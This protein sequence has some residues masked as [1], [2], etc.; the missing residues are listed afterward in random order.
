ME[1]QYQPFSTTD[2][3]LDQADRNISQQTGVKR[4]L[5]Y[6]LYSVPLLLLLILLLVIGVIFSQMKKEMTDVKLQLQIINKRGPMSLCTS[7]PTDAKQ[8]LVERIVPVRG[9]CKEGWASFQGSCYLLSTTTNV[10]QRA[11][12]QC[13]SSGGHLLVLNNVEELD[14][15]SGIVDIKYSYWIGLVERQHEGHW[16]W[17]DGTDFGS[18]PTFWDQG[19]PDNWDFRVNGEDCGQLHASGNRKRK[20][21][22]DADC[23]L[24]YRYICEAKA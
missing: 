9:T 10:W 5:T 8:V 22:N 14:Y 16:S 4:I 23:S 18:T 19:Q 17:V 21:W 11:E 13:R 24:G 2:S 12:D 3:S 20:L 15:I 7:G 6:I 1:T